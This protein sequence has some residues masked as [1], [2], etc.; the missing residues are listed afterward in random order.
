MRFAQGVSFVFLISY[1]MYYSSPLR[2]VVSLFG[3]CTKDPNV[4]L[5]MELMEGG[6]L[7]DLLAEDIELHW[8]T[9]LLIA[10]DIAR[11]IQVLHSNKP[12]VIECNV[13]Y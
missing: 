10:I 12:Q 11:G 3:A 2:Y 6:T 7:S 8:N 13:D 9:R 5:V 1:K 4:A